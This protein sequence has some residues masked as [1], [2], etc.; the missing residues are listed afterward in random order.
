[1]QKWIRIPYTDPANSQISYHQSSKYN[2]LPELLIK[3]EEEID[4]NGMKIT[5]III[6]ELKINYKADN[7]QRSETQVLLMECQIKLHR[8]TIQQQVDFHLFPELARTSNNIATEVAITS[9]MTRISNNMMIWD[10]SNPIW[11]QVLL[12]YKDLI[13][14]HLI[15]L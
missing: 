3:M 15:D 8:L 12:D 4:Y 11:N 6:S 9:N 13:K 5:Q 14:H 10:T 7:Q 1:M 2:Q